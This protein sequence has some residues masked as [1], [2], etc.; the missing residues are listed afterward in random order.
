MII[1]II[2]IDHTAGTLF[3]HLLLCQQMGHNQM[4]DQSVSKGPVLVKDATHVWL[5]ASA[6]HP[7][8]EFELPRVILFPPLCTV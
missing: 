3:M 5:V 2:I 8:G 4:P 6:V 1:G 7:K